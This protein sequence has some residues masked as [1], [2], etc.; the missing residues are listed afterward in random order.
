MAGDGGWQGGE[1]GREAEPSGA[2]PAAAAA[3]A[4]AASSA[5]TAAAAA[6]A[7]SA[8]A[9]ER[10]HVRKE[11]HLGE[12]SSLLSS[13]LPR[14]YSTRREQSRCAQAKLLLLPLLASGVVTALLVVL[15]LVDPEAFWDA[16]T[17]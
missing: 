12:R 16:T 13:L 5:A 7:A 14:S 1:G 11:D 10:S 17:L 4:A 8:A 15:F 2:P 9:G 3:A 6:A